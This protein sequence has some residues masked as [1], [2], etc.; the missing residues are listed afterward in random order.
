MLKHLILPLSCAFI[1]AACSLTP[2]QEAELIE[3][4]LLNLSDASGLFGTIKEEYPEDFAQLIDQIQAMPLADRNGEPGKQLGV[5]FIQDFMTRIVP[6]ATRA[7]AAELLVWSATEAKLYQTLQRSATDA[8]ASMTLGNWI[9]VDEANSVARSAIE[10]RNVAMIQAAAAGR[11]DPQSYHEPTEAQFN[12]LGDAIAATGLAPALQATLG[13][14]P[15]MQTLA[16]DDQC[17]LGVAFYRGI[18]ALPDDVEPAVAAY[19]FAPE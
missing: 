5:Q 16:I 6:E 15:Q 18:A 17:T 19:M 2:E 12:E 3:R 7:P 13:D 11:D 4:E 14:L 10:R 8:C 1:L 9:F